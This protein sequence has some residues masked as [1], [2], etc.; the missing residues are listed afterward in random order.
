MSS[1]IWR[2]DQPYNDL[3]LLPP[4][5]ELETRRVLK[6]CISARAAL[7]E[8]SQA[9]KLSPN[10]NILISTLP[11]LEAQA[12]SEIENIVTTADKL[13][14]ALPNDT[15]ADAATRE[16]LRYRE[17]LLSGFANITKRP[18]GTSTAV[19]VVGRIRDVNVGIRNEE[20]VR[21]INHRTGQPIFTP[22]RGEKR[23]RDLLANWEAFMHDEGDSLDPLVKLAVGHYQ[24][25]AIHP[26][27][28]GNGRT[29]RVLN[30]LYLIEAGL[31]TAPVLYLSR[32]INQTRA[33]YYRLLLEVTSDQAWERWVLYMV[34]GIEQT[35]NWT[36]AKIEAI[37]S[38]MEATRQHF[39]DARPQIYRQELLD[40][41]FEWPYIRI[42][43][44]VNSG[45]VE[46]QTASRYLKELALIGVLEEVP[47][48][49]EKLFIHTRLLRLLTVEGN[50]FAPF[51]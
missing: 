18:L 32:Y 7:A 24:F 12:S 15:S 31:L 51:S 3:P 2:P 26:F 16:A 14:Q 25:E 21:I 49:R 36:L 23:L 35:S 17:A 10:Q 28:D 5:V 48:G 19:A 37:R 1:P 44:V 13:F 9:V 38:L 30:T 42:A 4:S 46:R 45:L 6:A 41:I 20:D 50:E 34:N 11:V 40:L 29:G 39:R 27:T 47:I 43:N 8:L 33:N 22:P